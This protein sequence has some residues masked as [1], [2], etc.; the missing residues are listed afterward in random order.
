MDYQEAL[1]LK[2][3]RHHLQREPL[4]VIAEKDEPRIGAD[5]SIGGRV[6]LESQATM[7]DDVARAFTGYPV[8]GRGASPLQIHT[9]SLAVLSDNIS[10][11]G[12]LVYLCNGERFEVQAPDGWLRNG[13]PIPILLALEVL[14]PQLYEWAIR[15]SLDGVS[16]EDMTPFGM[17]VARILILAGSVVDLVGDLSAP[18]RG[19]LKGIL[20]HRRRQAAA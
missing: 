11:R 6:L 1:V 18:R 7:L 15:Q 19:R 10:S 5:G 20:P 12:R 8:L 3:D 16:D 9:G 17:E 14:P 13:K 4:C 2:F